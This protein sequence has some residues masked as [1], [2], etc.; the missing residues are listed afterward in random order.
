MDKSCFSSFP[1]KVSLEY[2][3]GV[4]LVYGASVVSP[5]IV[6]LYEL[7]LPLSSQVLGQ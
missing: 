4:A 7:S 5:F 6:S 2:P 3:E 1:K